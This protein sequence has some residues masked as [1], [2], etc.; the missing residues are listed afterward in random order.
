M[1]SHYIIVWGNASEVW[2]SSYNMAIQLDGAAKLNDD[3]VTLY[4]GLTCLE[5]AV[6]ETVCSKTIFT[7]TL[8]KHN[9]NIRCIEING[10]HLCL[11]T[12]CWHIQ[13]LNILKVLT[14]IFSFYT[15]QWLIYMV[16]SGLRPRIH[17][18]DTINKEWCLVH[19]FFYI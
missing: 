5:V 17:T 4:N 3:C 14:L 16:T 10:T 2:T 1:L 8:L 6:N 18:H 13:T 19:I 12:V 15:K 9:H 11:L 7:C